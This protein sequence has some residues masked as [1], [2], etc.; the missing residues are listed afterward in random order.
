MRNLLNLLYFPK[1]Y[2]IVPA[3]SLSNVEIRTD[4]AFPPPRIVLRPF[5]KSRTAS[6]R[7]WVPVRPFLCGI[8]PTDA[9]TYPQDENGVI[10]IEPYPESQDKIG[11]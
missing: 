3:R 7:T 1:V 4:A 9:R 8:H 2:E 6:T 11:P 5:K 10:G